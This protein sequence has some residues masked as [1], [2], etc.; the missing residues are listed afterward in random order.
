MTYS[1]VFEHVVALPDISCSSF[2]VTCDWILL[3]ETRQHNGQLKLSYPNHIE[4]LM[5]PS[6][7]V[8]EHLV[9]SGGEGHLFRLF[10]FLWIF[11]LFLQVSCSLSQTLNN[12]WGNQSCYHNHGA[13]TKSAKTKDPYPHAAQKPLMI[14][15]LH[16]KYF[17]IEM[18]K[19]IGRYDL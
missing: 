10:L 16:R 14:W 5:L 4:T 12:F 7:N 6:T 3:K 18:T 13:T 19:F 15:R 1:R 8:A 17:V 11:P 2:F 9:F